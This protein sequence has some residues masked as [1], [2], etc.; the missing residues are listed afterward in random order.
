MDVERVPHLSFFIHRLSD[1]WDHKL[2]EEIIN[3]AT[4]IR[5]DFP[6]L[7]NFVEPVPYRVFI[8]PDAYTFVKIYSQEN[9]KKHQH[10]L[11]FTTYIPKKSI[12]IS[13]PE[14]EGLLLY[15]IVH[16]IKWTESLSLCMDFPHIAGIEQQPHLFHF[17]CR[18]LYMI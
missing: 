3:M 17:F 1:L 8:I 15:R 5:L 16:P 18:S 14:S 9:Q 7:F 4:M 6:V 10:K 11:L 13:L 2:C 12:T